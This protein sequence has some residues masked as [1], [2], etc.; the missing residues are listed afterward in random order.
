M[1]LHIIAFFIALNTF[2]ALA[3]N[4][5]IDILIGQTDSA[6]T[7]Y[8]ND[9]IKLRPNPAY[10]IEKN[11]TK[12][13]N[14]NLTLKFSLYDEEFFSC[15]EVSTS[16]ARINGKELCFVQFVSGEIKFA[17]NYLSY[18]K[19]NFKKAGDG[20]WEKINENEGFKIVATFTK[21]GLDYFMLSFQL[22]ATSKEIS[23]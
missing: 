1:R 9:L 10:K 13:G 21:V 23:S 8:F 6:V 5:Q 4:K 2:T 12:N 7:N 17:E 3:Q 15:S 19:D 18:I 11:F 16:F 20:I 22:K 14:L